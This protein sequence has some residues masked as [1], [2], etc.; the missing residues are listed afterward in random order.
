MESGS[1]A[2][3]V[4][5]FLAT[6]V[7]SGNVTRL[8]ARRSAGWPQAGISLRSLLGFVDCDGS[9]GSEQ[10]RDRGR[11]HAK[12]RRCK[13]QG[14]SCRLIAV[15]SGLACSGWVVFGRS[16]SHF[17]GRGPF[18]GTVRDPL[19]KRLYRGACSSGDR[20]EFA[21]TCGGVRDDSASGAAE[22]ATG[23]RN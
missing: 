11:Y 22:S 20:G 9:T 18:V 8:M 21:G 1:A 5:G 6:A 23:R 3:S 10:K 14:D 13:E 7:G 2:G 12:A 16:P 17:F 4:A 15:G 19:W